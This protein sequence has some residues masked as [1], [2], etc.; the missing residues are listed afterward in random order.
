MHE[1][2][3]TTA[4]GNAGPERV[5]EREVVDQFAGARFSRPGDLDDDLRRVFVRRSETQC[6]EDD[7]ERLGAGRDEN[8][9]EI[10]AY[11]GE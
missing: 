10:D 1:E 3:R 4:G 5:G 8:G 2:F 6:V 7:V 9:G 11:G